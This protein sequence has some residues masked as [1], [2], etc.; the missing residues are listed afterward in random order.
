MAKRRLQRRVNAVARV[1]GGAT[2]ESS[3]Y[4]RLS[5]S[6]ILAGAQ[7]QTGVSV[8][9]TT[10]LPKLSPRAQALFM[11]QHCMSVD[12]LGA[13]RKTYGGKEWACFATGREGGYTRNFRG[14][15]AADVDRR[16]RGLP[17]ES[18]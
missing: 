13:L 17:N 3:H 15:G 7:I 11:T 5:I 16:P 8:V 1:A 9:P 2:R 4:Y 14:S 6:K 12:M 18:A 10:G